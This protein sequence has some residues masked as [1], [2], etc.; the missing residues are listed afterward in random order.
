VV[1]VIASGTALRQL[2]ED[3]RRLIKGYVDH[4]NDI[5]LNSACESRR[6]RASNALTFFR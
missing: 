6:Y 4:Y 5:R 1:T 2:D 3:A